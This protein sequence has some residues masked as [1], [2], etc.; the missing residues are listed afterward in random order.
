MSNK[1][2]NKY[3]AAS[4]Y[5][6][7]KP[8]FNSNVSSLQEVKRPLDVPLGNGLCNNFNVCHT[9]VRATTNSGDSYLIHKGANFGNS[10]QTIVAPANI[11]SNNW[12]N[13][14]PNTQAKPNTQIKDLVKTGGANYN[15]FT[16]NCN[17]AS[18]KII[19]KYGK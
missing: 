11:M 18:S 2:F 13:A 6:D 4:S 19:K 7:L 16:N 1:K 9:G 12:K 8:L 14:G 5:A 10:S 3:P 17:D 15:V